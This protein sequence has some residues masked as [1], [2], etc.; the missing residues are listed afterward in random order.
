MTTSYNPFSLDKKTILITG[1][2]SG[3]GRATAVECSK[4]GASVIITGRNEERLNETLNLLT[5]GNH[6]AILADL[7]LE[8]GINKLIECI[9]YLDGLVLA[10]GIE[11]MAL[12]Q[13]ST[14]S[15]L[16]KIYNNNL[17]SPIEILRLIVKKKK[18][19][20]GFSVVGIASIAAFLQSPAHGIYGSAK[21]A[22]VSM[23][24]YAALE[25]APKSIRINTISPGA[26]KTQMTM[27]A[28]S[29]ISQ[30]Q[31]EIN[32]KKYPLKHF[33]EPEDIAFGCIYLLSDAAKWITGEDLIIDG[34]IT[35]VS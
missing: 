10:A 15:K 12:F 19:R 11:G 8:E 29:M 16:E 13:F 33:G 35:L 25:L 9:P 24:K 32:E 4:M 30:E 6:L 5:P 23:F 26:I 2:S 3:I 1:A 7:S 18:F 22:L 31:L 27:T 28:N 20:S 17:F 34:G 14:K 21:A